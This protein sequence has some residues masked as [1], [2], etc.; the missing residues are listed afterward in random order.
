M[1]RPASSLRTDRATAGSEDVFMQDAD[2]STEA[3]RDQ[4][5]F[6]IAVDYGT[7]C[8]SVSYFSYEGSIM[9]DHDRIRNILNYLCDPL[10]F[11]SA[12]NEV[13]TEIWYPD[14]EGSSIVLLAI[15]PPI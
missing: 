7:T 8:S 5:C 11:R 10:P 13:P 15:L 9:T 1:L 4:K 2:I 6:V 14:G 12:S 3:S